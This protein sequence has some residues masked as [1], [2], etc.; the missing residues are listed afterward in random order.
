MFSTTYRPSP[1]PSDG[2]EIPLVLLFQSPKYVTHCKM[3]KFVQ[4]L[5]DYTYTGTK[6]NSSDEEPEEEISFS[7][8]EENITRS[9]RKR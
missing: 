6:A 5:Y 8:E 9:Q 2:L 1:I 4:T 7:V 3:K